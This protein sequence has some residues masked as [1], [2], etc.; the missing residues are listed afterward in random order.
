MSVAMRPYKT[1]CD[2]PQ[3][4]GTKVSQF[5]GSFLVSFTCNFLFVFISQVWL[6]LLC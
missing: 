6:S 4:T 5:L 1:M 2:K 3:I